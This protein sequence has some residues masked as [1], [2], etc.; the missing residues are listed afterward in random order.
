MVKEAEKELNKRENPSGEV[1]E[2]DKGAVGGVLEKDKGAVCTLCSV[3]LNNMLFSMN[4]VVILASKKISWLVTF[5]LTLA[6]R[7]VS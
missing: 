3:I 4:Y 6:N 5:K 1:L 7:L 2:K